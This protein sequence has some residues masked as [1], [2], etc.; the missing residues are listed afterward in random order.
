METIHT[1]AK[2]VEYASNITYYVQ[3]IKTNNVA[4]GIT[5]T[6]VKKLLQKESCLLFAK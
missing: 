4:K 6:F 5:L 1:Y 3:F 2:G